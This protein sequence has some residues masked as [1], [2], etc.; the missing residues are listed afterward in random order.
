MSLVIRKLTTIPE[1]D[2]VEINAQVIDET[3]RKPRQTK[4]KEPKIPKKRGRKAGV[5]LVEVTKR[6]QRYKN[7]KVDRERYTELLKTEEEYKKIIEAKKNTVYLVN[8]VSI[9]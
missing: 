7:I 1:I 3:P 6:E 9:E 2:E 5:K 4:P 8:T